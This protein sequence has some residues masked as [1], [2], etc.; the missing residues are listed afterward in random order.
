MSVRIDRMPVYNLMAVV[1]FIDHFSVCQEQYSEQ[2]HMV[3]MVASSS[4]AIATTVCLIIDDDE[5]SF[6]DRKWN[7]HCVFQPYV[8]YRISLP[9]PRHDSMVNLLRVI[10][11][12]RKICIPHAVRCAF[13]SCNM[14]FD[15]RNQSLSRKYKKKNI[16][17]PVSVVSMETHGFLFLGFLCWNHRQ[18]LF[19][20]YLFLFYFRLVIRSGCKR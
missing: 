7:H 13:S 9:L 16:I 15:W 12:W 8:S 14:L 6:N 10:V 18:K 5:W 1:K 4:F 19:L 17:S 11:N 20:F 3:N 2:K